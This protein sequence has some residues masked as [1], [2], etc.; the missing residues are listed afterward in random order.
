MEAKGKSKA[1]TEEF[2][3]VGVSHRIT[4]STRKMIAARI[5]ENGPLGCILMREPKNQADENAIKVI[6]DDGPYSE[7]HIG[8]LPRKVAAQ[9]APR[10]DAGKVV[11]KGATLTELTPE[12]GDGEI[13]VSFRVVKKARK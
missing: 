5:R 8:Y 6:L 7:M 2:S 12:D 11:I 3:V 10:W 9:F 13:T 4:L 1:K